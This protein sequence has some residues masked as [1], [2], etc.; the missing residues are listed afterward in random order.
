MAGFRI[1]YNSDKYLC[2]TQSTKMARF[3]RSLNTVSLY[4]KDHLPKSDMIRFKYRDRRQECKG[5]CPEK[6]TLLGTIRSLG[7]VKIQSN[8]KNMLYAVSRT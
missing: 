3:K 6:Y 5:W 4:E 7:R 2:Q 1:R 8:Y